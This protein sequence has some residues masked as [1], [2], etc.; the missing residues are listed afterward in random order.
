MEAGRSAVASAEENAFFQFRELSVA[1]ARG[2]ELVK[3]ASGSLRAGRMNAIIGPSGCGKTT[4]VKGILGLAPQVRGEIACGGIAVRKSDELAGSVGFAPQFSIAHRKLTVDECLRY[5]LHLLVRE[6]E[7]R[8]RRLAEILRRVGLEEHREKVVQNLSG[9]Q[10]R[11]L[12]LGLEMVTDPACLICDEVTSGLDPQSEEQILLLLRELCRT[13]GKTVVCII[14][15]LARLSLFDHITVLYQ[16]RLVFEGS[17]AELHQFF[18]I[19]DV[20]FLYDRLDEKPVDEWVTLWAGRREKSGPAFPASAMAKE[21]P[22]NRPNLPSAPAQF[23]W[24]LRRRC[25][26]F[27]RDRGALALTLGITFGFPLLVVIFAAGGLPQLEGMRLEFN[28]DLMAGARERGE[29]EV[30]AAQTAALISGL[31]M[32]QVILL[33]LLGS[34]NGAREIAGERAVYEKERLSGVRPLSY[35]LA[36]ACFVGGLAA[37]QGIWMTVFVKTICGFPGPWVPQMLTLGAATVAMAL[38]SL[39]FSAILH[40]PERASLL[41]VYLVGFQLPLSGVVLALPEGLVWLI[42]PFI[43]AYWSWAGYLSTMKE[44]RFYDAVRMASDDWLAPLPLAIAVMALQGA[45]GLALAF[46]G[47]QK[48]QWD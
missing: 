44:S 21:R 18:G 15:N 39:G 13:S 37:A 27:W 40:S 9:G 28:P 25:H 45:A 30:R 16:G 10:L 1:T 2:E 29:F 8:E 42:R 46:W 41:S 32:F 24:L 48:K 34:N 38:V 7:L 3:K 36:K 4:L 22:L 5:A 19:E 20:H 23:L 47:C 6:E 35:L 31:V 43:T 12:G 33:T 17:L 11:R 26:L 14:H